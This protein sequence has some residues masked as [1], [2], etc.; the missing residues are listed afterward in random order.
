MAE[1]NTRKRILDAAEHFFA[2]KG[3]HNCSVREITG[4]ARVNLAAVNYHF[5]SKERLLETV[6]DRRLIPLN[7]IRFEKLEKITSTARAENRLLQINEIM[8]A[9]IEPTMRVLDSS[10][11]S[12][13]FMMIICRVQTDPDGTIRN[14]FLKKVY[15]LFGAYFTALCLALPDV[16]KDVVFTRFLFAI[17][18]MAHSM[19]R[20]NH[21]ELAENLPDGISHN[22]DTNI[23]IERLIGFVSKGMEGL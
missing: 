7:R 21:P 18:A 15:E 9:F 1:E 4:K 17:G 23:L 13:D 2:Q 14:L 5:G 12:R 8:R 3:Y 11:G 6:M 22:S 19:M 16:S 10:P 20:V